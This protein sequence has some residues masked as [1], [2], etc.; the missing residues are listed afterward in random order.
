MIVRR[1]QLGVGIVGRKVLAVGGSDGSLRLSS[2]ECYDP[3]TGCWAFVSPM[4]TC[5]SGVA[6]GVLGGAMYAVGGYDGRLV[7]TLFIIC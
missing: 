6:V 7:F 2:V 1:Q 5:R 3:N 4:Q